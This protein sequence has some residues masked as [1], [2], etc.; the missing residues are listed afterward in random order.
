M[1][2]HGLG[3]FAGGIVLHGDGRHRYWSKQGVEEIRSR[4][5]GKRG[6]RGNVTTL[7]R[8]SSRR[9]RLGVARRHT[10]ERGRRR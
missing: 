1:I 5:G 2:E 6:P 9:I 4:A 7:S 8:S 3:M 10:W